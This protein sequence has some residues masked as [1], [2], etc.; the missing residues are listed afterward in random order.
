MSLSRASLSGPGWSLRSGL[1]EAI[2]KM[3]T[4]QWASEELIYVHPEPSL[5]LLPGWTGATLPQGAQ[6]HTDT[7]S[8]AGMLGTY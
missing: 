8:K 3:E 1:W 6:K 4:D 5:T 7:Q 2:L